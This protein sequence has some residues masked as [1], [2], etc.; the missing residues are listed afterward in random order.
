MNLLAHEVHNTA[1]SNWTHLDVRTWSYADNTNIIDRFAGST[2]IMLPKIGYA[3]HVHFWT[4]NKL[5]TLHNLLHHTHIQNSHILLRLLLHLVLFL[6]FS[7]SS[8]SNFHSFHVYASTALSSPSTK[9]GR[10]RLLHL[11]FL[12]LP[13]GQDVHCPFQVLRL[14]FYALGASRA[15]PT[16]PIPSF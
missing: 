12:A 14:H 5:S 4:F 6:S 10:Y 7:S 8:S 9:C 13:S 11:H 2:C 1:M 3:L 16:D 15:S